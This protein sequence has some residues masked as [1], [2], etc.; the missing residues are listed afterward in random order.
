MTKNKRDYR[1]YLIDI[2][3]SI[4]DIQ[5]FIKGMSYEDF[6]H[7][8]KTINAV[9]RSIEIIGEATKNLPQ[10]IKE[11]D[12][13]IPWKK[14]AGMR[15][16]MIHEYFGIDYTIVWKTAKNTL[17]KLKNKLINIQKQEE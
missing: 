14:M 2:V 17:P 16:K 11:K 13:T 1:D 3:N 9:V 7:D 6:F 5:S 8:N 4:A 10:T 15:D 12:E